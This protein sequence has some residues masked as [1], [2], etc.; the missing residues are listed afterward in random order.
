MKNMRTNKNQLL[1][2]LVLSMVLVVL[3]AVGCKKEISK[4]GEIIKPNVGM[5]TEGNGATAKLLRQSPGLKTAVKD[6]NSIPRIFPKLQGT[7]KITSLLKEFGKKKKSEAITTSDGFFAA[8][9]YGSQYYCDVDFPTL[10]G[11]FDVYLLNT[12]TWVYTYVGS[13]SWINFSFTIDKPAMYG[14]YVVWAEGPSESEF[15]SSLYLGDP[16]SG[17]SLVNGIL[18]FT[19]KNALNAILARLEQAMEDHSSNFADPLAYMTDDQLTDY[20]ISVGFDEFLPMK[21]FEAYFGFYSLRQK[22]ETEEIAWLATS[23]PWAASVYPDD[24]YAIEDDADRT[25]NNQ[26]GQVKVDGNLIEPI[27]LI[28]YPQEPAGCSVES[29]SCLERKRNVDTLHW[30]GKI[31]NW[32]IVKREGQKGNGDD[33]WFDSYVKAKVRRFRNQN[34]VWTKHKGKM[35]VQ[36]VGKVYRN[37]GYGSCTAATLYDEFNETKSYKRKYMR[38]ERVSWDRY[39]HIKSCEVSATFNVDG[40]IFTKYLN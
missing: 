39:T 25:V 8:S 40:H 1:T 17:V 29:W 34:G 4:S 7:E 38:K 23:N 31:I 9:L 6:K 21:E 35:S 10:T 22:I 30:E 36:I 19:D 16:Y 2:V 11:G 24:G 32:K 15:S 14:N 27:S 26:Y 3:Y 33:L 28:E 18:E 37:Y 20:A 12:N 13:S 5:S